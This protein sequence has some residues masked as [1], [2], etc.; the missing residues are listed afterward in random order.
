MS[1]PHASGRKVTRKQAVAGALA[2]AGALAL[3]SF[4]V[5]EDAL[6][7]TLD[8]TMALFLGQ[9][10]LPVP[11]KSAK[12]H[13]SACQFCNVGCGYKIYTWP[14]KATP[15]PP[16]ADG[17][18][19]KE[20][21]ADWISP[22]MVTRTKVGG[23]DSYVAVVPDKDCIV[24]KGDHSPRGGTNALTI[25][26]TRKHPL[27][28]PTERHL[29]AQVR[30]AKGG[31]LRQVS[32]DEAIDR[33]VDRIKQVLDTSTPS[34]IGVWAAD[35]L[36]PEMNFASTKLFFA[37]R[38]RGLLQPGAR[39]RP[40]RGRPGHPQPP[41]VELRAPEHRRQLRL[42]LD[43]P[44]LLPGLRAGRHGALLRGEQLRDRDRPLQPDRGQEEQE[45]R[46]RPAQDGAGPERRGP[47]RRAPA[48]QAQH[49]RRAASTR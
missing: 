41:Q 17:P 27:T 11:P 2:G 37:P 36:S 34:S 15:K 45:G 12:L 20:A 23:V 14:V 44:L 48:A 5:A 22:T 8:P 49:R 47:R 40:G 6:G 33:V 31:K 32:L 28:D 21:L 9:D 16:G 4:L 38:P 18:Y 46:H 19:P 35:H 39:P 25:Y 1:E 13:T 24:N 30:D 7:A 10:Q 3:P 26:T 42:G 43:P 29:R